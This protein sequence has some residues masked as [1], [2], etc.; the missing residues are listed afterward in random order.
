MRKIETIVEALFENDETQSA[1][2][3]QFIAYFWQKYAST[4]EGNPSLNGGVFE[5]LIAK[6]LQKEGLLPFYVQAKVAFIPNVDYDFI[7]YTKERGPIVLSCKTS[8]R[9]RYKQADLEALALKQIH[10]KSQSFVLSLNK[11]EVQTR[12]KKLDE[13]MAIDDFIDAR[14]EGFDTFI[15][16]L[17]EYTCV[18]A[19]EVPVIRSNR[20]ID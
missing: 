9:E 2:P 6:V 18:L 8:L 15:E 19:P 16:M 14:D 5:E 13:V 4:Y 20:I 11:K 1:T 12:R 17:K 10:R 3:S 7:L